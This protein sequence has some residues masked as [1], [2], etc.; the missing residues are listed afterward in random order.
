M[1]FVRSRHCEQRIALRALTKAEIMKETPANLTKTLYDLVR[2]ERFVPFSILF[3][4]FGC[5]GQQRSP[6]RP[7]HA[8]EGI[9]CR[10][11]A[12]LQVCRTIS[13]A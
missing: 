2:A 1:L 5:V 4:C 7:R 12:D 10:P 8:C 13:S 3:G 6:A 11:G 9:P